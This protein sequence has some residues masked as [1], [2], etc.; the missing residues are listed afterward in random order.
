MSNELK[1]LVD[2]P[3]KIKENLKDITPK[4]K[5]LFILETTNKTDKLDWVLKNM[6]KDSQSMD[7]S[8]TDD[9]YSTMSLNDEQ[10]LVEVRTISPAEDFEALLKRGEK[11]VVLV[12]QIQNI[13]SNLVFKAVVIDDD[14]V[15][16]AIGIYREEAKQLGAFNYNEWIAEFKEIILKQQKKDFWENVIV[17]QKLGLITSSETETSFTTDADAQKFY[18]TTA[19]ESKNT[20]TGEYDDYIAADDLLDEI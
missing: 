7:T 13:I 12:K 15:S 20:E 10:Q 6:K 19:D 8:S 5:E 16:K 1:Q 2:I 17:Q 11:F 9:G 18:S 3:V 14:K 4:I